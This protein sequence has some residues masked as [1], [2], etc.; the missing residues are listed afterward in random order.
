MRKLLFS[1]VGIIVFASARPQSITPTVINSSGGSAVSG[2]N[3]ANAF[4]LD[5]NVGEMALVN[6]MRTGGKKVLIITNG[7]LQPEYS[8]D[9]GQEPERIQ[10]LLT[11]AQV[12]AWPNPS[13]DQVNVNLRFEGRGTVKLLLT[14]LMGEQLY[15]KQ[16]AVN[17]TATMEQV[18]IGKYTPGTYLLQVQFVSE[19]GKISQGS[20]KIIKTD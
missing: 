20:F 8:G 10:P 5:W 2:N 18:S 13:S 12:F 19:E 9:Q 17:G 16:V 3:P 7:F 14:T 4:Y 11:G 1:L 15:T 6:T